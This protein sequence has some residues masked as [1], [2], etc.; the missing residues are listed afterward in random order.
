MKI[1]NCIDLLLCYVM[2]IKFIPQHWIL[3]QITSKTLIM[4]SFDSSSYM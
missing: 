4:S 3:L 2:I 1:L